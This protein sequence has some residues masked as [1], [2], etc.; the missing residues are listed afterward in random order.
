MYD[1]NQVTLDGKERR[2]FMGSVDQIVE[3][4]AAWKK[5]G[6]SEL[7][8]D[9]RSEALGETLERMEQ[10]VKTVKRSADGAGL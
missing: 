8:F 4:I 6:V 9:F 7:I 10:F 2:P 5:L 3:D 1:T